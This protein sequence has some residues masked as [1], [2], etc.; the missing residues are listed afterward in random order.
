[1]QLLYGFYGLLTC[2]LSP[3]DPPSRVLLFDWVM[4]RGMLLW[5]DSAW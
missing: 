3:P 5:L 1:M 4:L 2:L